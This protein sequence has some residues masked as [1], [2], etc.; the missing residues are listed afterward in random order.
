[1]FGRAG[2]FQQQQTQQSSS[3]LGGPPGSEF[4]NSVEAVIQTVDYQEGEPGLLNPK[5]L[6]DHID[7]L[8]KIHRLE[9]TVHKSK[10]KLEDLC[11]RAELPALSGMSHIQDSIPP[12]VLIFL[13]Q[14]YMEDIIPCL[15]VTPADCFYEGSNALAPG[16]VI[17]VP[18]RLGPK[19]FDRAL[20][21]RAH[22]T[23]RHKLRMMRMTVPYSG[24]KFR[25]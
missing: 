10:W 4:L 2:K 13:P 22:L 6:R 12:T 1:M 19:E 24:L 8:I 15:V 5:A 7:L 23:T 11:R 20:I 21:Q 25:L 16:K 14:S 3:P 18:C 9:V 17:H